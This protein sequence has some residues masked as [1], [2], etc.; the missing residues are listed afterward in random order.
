MSKYGEGYTKLKVC[1]EALKRKV[2]FNSLTL[3]NDAEETARRKVGC[4]KGRIT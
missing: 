1:Y 3:I 2:N 4:I